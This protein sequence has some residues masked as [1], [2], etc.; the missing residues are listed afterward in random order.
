[1]IERRSMI[2][3]IISQQAS[4]AQWKLIESESA[5]VQVSHIERENLSTA[6]NL[7]VGRGSLIENLIITVSVAYTIYV[8]TILKSRFNRRRCGSPRKK[9]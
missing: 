6:N 2:S 1:M 4:G 5:K 7:H 3:L 8:N 9:N